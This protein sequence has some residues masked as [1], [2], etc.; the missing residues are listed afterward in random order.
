MKRISIT[1]YLN[2]LYKYYCEKSKIEYNPLINKNV[3]KLNDNIIEIIDK[4]YKKYPMSK[5]INENILYD[6][7]A[8]YL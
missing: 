1:K 3:I 7:D 4:V 2:S 5:K 6:F 8:D